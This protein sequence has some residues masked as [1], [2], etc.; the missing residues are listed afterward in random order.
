MGRPQICN[1]RCFSCLT[2]TGCLVEGDEYYDNA[3]FI[4]IMKQKTPLTTYTLGTS[5]NFSIQFYNTVL[6]FT[7]DNIS[8]FLATSEESLNIM[9]RF[10]QTTRCLN[11]ILLPYKDKYNLTDI[12]RFEILE[13]Q[14][15]IEDNI[16]LSSSGT[17]VSDNLL[18]LITKNAITE[19]YFYQTLEFEATFI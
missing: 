1:C 19:K 4:F 14:N 6:N 10:F 16:Y 12:T 18:I 5:V 7:L 8:Q 9:K 15:F 2:P 17:F 13:K 3:D 11:S